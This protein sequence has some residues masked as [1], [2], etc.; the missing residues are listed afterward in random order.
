MRRAEQATEGGGVMEQ[1][2]ELM[3]ARARE[4]VEKGGL[5]AWQIA[6]RTGVSERTVQ[7]M[8]RGSR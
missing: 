7:R 6:E 2:H 1:W 8:M 3:L 4:L 5:T